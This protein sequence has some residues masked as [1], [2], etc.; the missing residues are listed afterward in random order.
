MNGGS[1]K[2]LVND[3]LTDKEF[4]HFWSETYL[5]ENIPFQMKTMRTERGLRQTEAAEL[6]GK[7]QN[8]LSRLE[9]P[10]YGRLSLQTLLEVARG[11][12]VGLVVKFVPFS[13]LLREYE[14]VTF[15]ALS[16]PSP[17]PEKFPEEIGE[18]EKWATEK[19]DDSLWEPETRTNISTSNKFLKEPLSVRKAS[20][21]FTLPMIAEVTSTPTNAGNTRRPT[22]S[23]LTGDTDSRTLMVGT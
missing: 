1:R 20:G 21:A 2:E 10:A 18:I 3:I 16:A 5:K 7:G 19:I 6:L 8:G 15:D 23:L 22:P 11:Y 12:D 14:D 9:S 17:D 13:R 4:R